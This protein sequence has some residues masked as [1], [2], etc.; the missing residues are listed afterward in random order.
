MTFHLRM[1][2]ETTDG[3]A[4]GGGTPS[5]EAP[6]GWY[7]APESHEVLS[8]FESVEALKSRLAPTA[9]DPPEVWSEFYGR[10]GRPES[11]AEYDLSVPLP[12]ELADFGMNDTEKAKWAETFHSLGLSQSHVSKLLEVRAD[13]VK[14]FAEEAKQQQEAQKKEDETNLKELYGSKLG[15]KQKQIQEFVEKTLSQ[16]M[17]EVGEI[18]KAN[19]DLISNPYM[20][21]LL[22]YMNE[23]VNPT[24]IPPAVPST[25]K[26]S[27]TSK[28]AEYLRQVA[29]T[30]RI[31]II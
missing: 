27:A 1:L 10:L 31:P 22:D 21:Q 3:G 5:P 28:Q 2:Q 14:T 11:P 24:N 30:G 7:T 9:E 29:A 15:V 18:F 23:L 4:E 13:M 25:G 12:E 19:G 26:T 8:Q 16:K 20:F 6:S 17:P